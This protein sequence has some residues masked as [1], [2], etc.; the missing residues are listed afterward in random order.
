MDQKDD[1]VRK[2]YLLSLREL[3]VGVIATVTFIAISCVVSYLMGYL[4]SPD[5]IG[6]VIGFP[7]WIFWGVLVP[8][9]LIVA[10][11]VY[12]GLVKMKGEEK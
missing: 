6:Y 7:D 4:R 5:E 2:E 8:W 1:G 11:T 9:I 10:F 12:Y 3:K